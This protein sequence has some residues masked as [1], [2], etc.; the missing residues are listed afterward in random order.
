MSFF[1]SQQQ[2]HGKGKDKD[3]TDQGAVGHAW[4]GV[5]GVMDA[6]GVAGMKGY[7]VRKGLEKDRKMEEER[8]RL[9][10]PPTFEEES[11]YKVSDW[12]A[13]TQLKR[14]T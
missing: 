5:E 7:D 14:P 6:E 1:N 3:R 9:L 8:K 11:K 12:V 4:E 10:A 13:L 2:Q